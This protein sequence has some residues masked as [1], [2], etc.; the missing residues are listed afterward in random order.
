[1]TDALSKKE[2]RQKNNFAHFTF[3]HDAS[4]GFNAVRQEFRKVVDTS[5]GE[6]TPRFLKGARQ[7]SARG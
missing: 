3:Y 5:G 4:Q 1:M 7:P 6:P 2:C